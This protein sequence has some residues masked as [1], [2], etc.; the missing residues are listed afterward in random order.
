[1]WGQDSA[2]YLKEITYFAGT[3]LS[4]RAEGIRAFPTWQ[5]ANCLTLSL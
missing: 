1:M 2:H 4:P 5:A 3:V